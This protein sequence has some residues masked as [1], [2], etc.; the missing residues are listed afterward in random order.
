MKFII[1]NRIVRSRVLITPEKGADQLVWFCESRPGTDWQPGE[2]YEK[3]K[4]AKTNPQAAD[5]DLARALWD[6]SEQLL[7]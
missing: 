1:N 5:A 4:P 7:G 6:R 3:R 2:Y